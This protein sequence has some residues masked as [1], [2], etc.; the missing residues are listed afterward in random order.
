MVLAR[1]FIYIYKGGFYFYIF[2]AEASVDYVRGK[3]LLN[4]SCGYR[5]HL[6]QEIIK[7]QR[8]EVSRQRDSSF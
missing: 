1:I 4:S 8:F 5:V 3:W 6:S 7:F 2:I